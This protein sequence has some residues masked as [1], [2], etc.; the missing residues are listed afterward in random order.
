[1]SSPFHVYLD[2]E[3]RNDDVTTS[4]KPPP[5]SFEETRLQPFLKGDASDYFCT[6]ARFT[7][8]TSNSIPV[9]IPEID[10]S[11]TPSTATL[12]NPPY[13]TTI[14][15]ITVKQ[16]ESS[17]PTKVRTVNL[18]YQPFDTT[19]QL[20][21]SQ[22]D[23]TNPSNTYYH[24]HT[25]QQLID[26]VNN[27]LILLFSTIQVA[28]SG[29]NSA[30]YMEWDPTSCTATLS[31]DQFYFDLRSGSITTKWE[32]YFNTRLYELFNT[33]PATMVNAGGDLNYR[34]NM[35]GNPGNTVLLSTKDSSGNP[36][37]NVAISQEI[38]TISNMSPLD[39]IV[40]TSTSLP[41][42][43]QQSTLPK[44][45]SSRDRVLSGNGLPNIMNVLTDFQ[46]ALS[47]N[48]H[49]KPEISYVPAGEYR[50]IDMYANSD[51]RR[52]DLQV[53]WKDRK[54]VLYPL[55]LYPG[56]TA[57]VKFLFRHRRFYL[58]D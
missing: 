46:I 37:Y 36:M 17:D 31:A 32:I 58:G 5:L 27:A 56:C 30:P 23:A 18:I 16:N 22:Q 57:S 2:L 28:G 50:L 39:S 12:L 1:M 55:L 54:G 15:K 9:F 51:L 10:F 44:V 26:M 4:S 21:V 14:Y 7:L 45:I 48:N 35:Y 11:V 43:P 34:L 29:H 20:P 40:F 8:Q 42:L 41:I 6:I 47:A 33:L 38:S 53:Y 52:I 24:V 3:V 13:Q 19:L 49:Y 25:Y